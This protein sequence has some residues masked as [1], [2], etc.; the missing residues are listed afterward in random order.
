[1]ISLKNDKYKIKYYKKKQELEDLL[2]RDNNII[3][4]YSHD[5][6]IGDNGHWKLIK[7]NLSNKSNWKFKEYNKDMVYDWVNSKV[8][9]INSNNSIINN[10]V[11]NTICCLTNKFDFHINLEGFDFIPKT[12]LIYQNKEDILKISE[13]IFKEGPVLLKSN[14]LELSE[15]VTLIKNKSDLDKHID[16]NEKYVLQNLIKNP[17]LYN[18]KAIDIRCYVIITYNIDKFNVY[19]FKEGY[20]RICENNYNLNDEKAIVVNKNKNNLYITFDNTQPDY[21]VI[22]KDL[23]N[24][25]KK[26]FK[27][28]IE[29]NKLKLMSHQKGYNILGLDFIQD[30]NDKMWFIEANHSPRL[31]DERIAYISK[32]LMET[33]VDISESL[34][35]H[36][37]INDENL[38]KI[39]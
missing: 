22:I 34:L 13:I 38:Y 14:R 32:K 4:I 8:S 39:I 11:N 24:I 23:I 10:Y 31:N 33:V 28:V 6:N 1:M 35:L 19:L 18:N 5:T 7:D 26:T 17:K 21:F 20:K 25:V 12:Y 29:N 30:I 2:N 16:Y 37:P 36:K 15:G 9:N 3:F 27:S